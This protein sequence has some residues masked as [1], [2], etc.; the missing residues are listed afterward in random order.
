M[1]HKKT[2]KSFSEKELQTTPAIQDQG[3][4][5]QTH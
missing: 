4:L 5:I 2:K 1:N 3:I